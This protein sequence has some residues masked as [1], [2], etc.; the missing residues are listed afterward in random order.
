MN[1]SVG[2]ID[3]Q[4]GLVASIKTTGMISTQYGYVILVL[5]LVSRSV[6]IVKNTYKALFETGFQRKILL[7]FFSIITTKP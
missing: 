7:G 6:L 1:A 3:F 4:I 2:V 5:P